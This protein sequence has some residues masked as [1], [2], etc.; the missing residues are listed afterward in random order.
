MHTADAD[1]T[2][3]A[4]IRDA[5][6]LAFATHGFQV[7]LR[8]IAKDAGVSVALITHHYGTKEALRRVCDDYVLERYE[9]IKL[10]AVADPHAIEGELA[11]MS[12]PSVLTVYMVQCFL[13]PSPATTAFFD[14]FVDRV[15][16]IMRASYEAGLVRYDVMNETS[17]RILAV[18]TVGHIVAE[19]ALNPPADPRRF[20]DDT[21]TLETI[22]ALMDLYRDGV[23]TDSPAIDQ[24]I[25]ALKT[26]NRGDHA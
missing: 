22:A 19:Y 2:A 24:Y 3:K 20:I 12:G 11:D 26:R 14:R 13:H 6:L 9:Q 10:M 5:A 15:R 4:R 16:A 23:F 25:E 21:Y 1:L 8:Q 18:R 17:L 7:P